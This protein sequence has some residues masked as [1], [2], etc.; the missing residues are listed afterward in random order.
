M[1]YQAM[2]FCAQNKKFDEISAE[3]SLLPTVNTLHVRQIQIL[4]TEQMNSFYG[5]FEGRLSYYLSECLLFV[6]KYIS[7]N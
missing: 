5:Q 2:D 7:D 3:F 6:A 4:R 1:R